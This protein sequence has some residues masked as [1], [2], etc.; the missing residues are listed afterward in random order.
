MNEPSPLSTTAS[1]MASKASTSLADLLAILAA[2]R[3]LMTPRKDDKSDLRESINRLVQQRSK[4]NGPTDRWSESQL[5][6][7]ARS[8]QVEREMRGHEHFAKAGVPKLH[9]DRLRSLSTDGRYAAWAAQWKALAAHVDDPDGCLVAMAGTRGAGKTQLGVCAIDRMCRGRGYSAMYVEAPFLFMQIRDSFRDSGGEAK[10]Y[11]RFT[12]PQLLFIDQMEERKH[13]EA[14]DR[15]LFS[16]VN[17]RYADCRHT[18][19]ASNESLVALS[20]SLGA[21]IVGRIN[22]TGVFIECCWE[23]LRCS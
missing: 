21:S 6:A 3:L 17:K 1:P 2:K 16:I 12:A 14:E 4:S 9:R 7:K 15:M 5:A 23:D 18:I 22:E 11:R 19:I 13:S 10:C 8:D 20:A